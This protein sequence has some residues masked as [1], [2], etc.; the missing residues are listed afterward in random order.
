MYVIDSH[1]HTIASGHAYSTISEYAAAAAEKGLA[2][3]AVTDHAPK[4]AGAPSELYFLNLPIL[5][6]FM[7]GVRVYTGAEVNIIDKG[8]RVDLPERIL[9]SLDVVIASL[10]TP[11]F[12]PPSPP[13]DATGAVT[14]AMRN[15]FVKIIGHLGDTRY[16]INE[17][18]VVSAAIKNN[19]LIEVNNSSFNPASRR[20]GGERRVARLLELCRRRDFP[21][22]LG[23]DAHFHGHVGDFSLLAG[24]L[25]GFPE[26]LILNTSAEKYEKFLGIKQGF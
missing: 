25:D 7:R 10:H 19:V 26:E 16:P 8:G 22:V 23:S 12:P 15:P 4:L 24:V 20:F 11:C 3:F 13:E 2:G 6:K 1:C 9:A 17:E 18:E 14:G 21:V 5:P